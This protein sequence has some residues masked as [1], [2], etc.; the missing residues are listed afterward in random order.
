MCYT[1]QKEVFNECV[2]LEFEKYAESFFLSKKK[3]RYCGYLSW[4]DGVW[5]DE[6]EFFVMG[7]EMKKSNETKLAKTVQ[8]KILQM[9][10]QGK[11]EED[12]TKY[13]KA[14]YKLVKGG[15]YKASSII[16][17]SRLR[18]PLEDYKSI[19]GGVAGV[20]FYNQ[21]IG[22]IEVGD[23]YYFY[24]VD[25]KGI[26]DF[27]RQYEVKGRIRNVEYI[28]FKKLEEVL[29]NFP[30]DWVRLADSEIT[31]KV[32]LI[33]ESLRWDLSA[34]ANDGKQTTLDSWW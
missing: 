3:N 13:A 24:T 11:T 7:F 28:A 6:N 5:L 16:K 9:V 4:K 10:A 1:K 14:M 29:E 2:V 32:T 20:L 31:K 8:S 25:N 18:T 19:A 17:Q 22:K 15:K 30:I 33:Y 34:I 12:V 26:K 21:E 23:S 27:P